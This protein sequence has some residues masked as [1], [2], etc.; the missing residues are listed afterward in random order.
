MSQDQAVG[1]DSFAVGVEAPIRDGINYSIRWMIE[2]WNEEQIAEAKKRLHKIFLP[3]GIQARDLHRLGI[4]PYDLSV[5]EGNLLTTAGL[6]RLTS[7]LTG[8]GGTAITNTTARIGVGNGAGTAAVGDTDLS[9]SAGSANRWFQVMDATYPQTAAGVLT[10]KSTFASGDGNFAWNE[11][12]VDIA[13]ATVTSGNTVNTTL[14]N[15]K[16][17]I[18]QG[19]KASGQVWAATAT[20]TFS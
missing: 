11:F 2:R 1:R 6:T 9:A 14:F 20:I 17:S 5:V 3:K 19:T 10:L 18:A 16:T 8:A 15:H 7:L 13:A 4:R 12:G